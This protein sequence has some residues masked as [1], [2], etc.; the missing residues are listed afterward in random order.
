MPAVGS[1]GTAVSGA[2]V[3]FGA[4]VPWMVRALAVRRRGGWE[5]GRMLCRGHRQIIARRRE[6][7]LFS[8]R[9][10]TLA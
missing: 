2:V 8:P 3:F 7:G 9:D 10:E 6:P 1:M 5:G 4:V